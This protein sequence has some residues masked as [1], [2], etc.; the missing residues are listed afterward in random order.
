[1]DTCYFMLIASVWFQEQKLIMHNEIASATFVHSAGALLI[2]CLPCADTLLGI[3][4]LL[5]L[6]PISL[7]MIACYF[8][9]KNRMHI[10]TS[11]FQVCL[12]CYQST[13]HSRNTN[14]YILYK[15]N[16]CIGVYAPTTPRSPAWR[17]PT[18][19]IA[20]NK[21]VKLNVYMYAF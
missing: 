18:R 19:Q 12:P 5:S 8:F 3:A 9:T 20:I 6:L 11:L 21:W 10:L 1:M 15:S 7:P 13:L 4:L 16:V 2:S 17:G 14:Y